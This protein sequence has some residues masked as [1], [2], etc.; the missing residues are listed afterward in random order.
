MND[1][2]HFFSLEQKIDDCLRIRAVFL[3]PQSKRLKTLNDEKRIERRHR[4]SNVS[5]KGDPGL[6]CVR[7]RSERFDRFRPDRTVIAGVGCIEG[8]LTLR[9]SR[10][11]KVAAIDD[12]TTDR[13]QM[14]AEIFRC[15]MPYQ[16]GTV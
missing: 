5:Q 10:P 8:R 3:H 16:R 6:D 12:Q 15:R 7:D 2:L 11:I 4:G 14:S 13:V 9:M 1:S